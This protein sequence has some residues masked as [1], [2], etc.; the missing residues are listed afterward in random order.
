MARSPTDAMENIQY[1]D[2]ISRASAFP[3]HIYRPLPESL[4][5][6]AFIPSPEEEIAIRE[7]IQDVNTTLAAVNDEIARLRGA[8]SELEEYR[9]SLHTILKHQQA[10]LSPIRRLP[11]E[12]LGEIFLFAS[13]GCTIQWPPSPRRLLA[14]AGQ[15]DMPWL[16]CQICSYW[17]TAAISFPKLWHSVHLNLQYPSRVAEA[18]SFLGLCLERSKNEL[19]TLSIEGNGLTAMLPILEMLLVHSERWEDVSLSSDFFFDFR[20]NF[21]LAKNRVPNL[22]RLCIETTLE[23]LPPSRPLEAF[24]DAPNLRE[25]SMTHIIHPLQNFRVPWSQITHFISKGNTFREGEFTQIMRH[26]TN[27]ISFSTEGE[28]I[29]EVASSQPVLLPHLEKLTI[30]NKGSYISKTFQFITAPNLQELVIHAITPFMAEQTVAMIIRSQCKP[31]RLAFRASLDIDALWDE[32]LGVVW[33]LTELPS[34]RHLELN[35]LKSAHHIMPRLVNSRKSSLP[36]LLPNLESFVL[37]DRFCV[38]A[39]EVTEVLASR[40]INFNSDDVVDSGSTE[41]PPGLRAIN[42]RLFPP[43]APKFPELDLLKRVAENHGV[44]ITIF[45]G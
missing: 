2:L 4:L 8:L 42:L 41:T 43:A 44:E 38:S 39:G 19:L 24:E 20:E 18:Q 12:I 30:I 28:R 11:P 22:R 25:L 6:S 32:N 36:S 1:T 31:Q 35:V 7:T 33:M 15:D 10:P 40:I 5:H 37:E 26:M 13:S 45:S 3:R 23:D 29:L 17:R 34:L 27:L 9:S 16:L 21:A 14:S